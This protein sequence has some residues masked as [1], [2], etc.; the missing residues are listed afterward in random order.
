MYSGM[1]SYLLIIEDLFVLL[2][3]LALFSELILMFEIFEI[4]V[5]SVSALLAILLILRI[6]GLGLVVRVLMGFFVGLGFCV[7]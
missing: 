6:Q 5:V 2:R 3:M 4:L 7:S 1:N